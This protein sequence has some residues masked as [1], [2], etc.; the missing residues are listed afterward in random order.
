MLEKGTFHF[1]DFVRISKTYPLQSLKIKK[2]FK[3]G[4][5]YK[6]RGIPVGRNKWSEKSEILKK[7]FFRKNTKTTNFNK[8]YNN[9]KNTKTT[10]F[11][12]T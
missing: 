7:N 4:S 11:R 1:H 2:A 3:D 8:F 9:N 12:I 10:N 5:G 6:I